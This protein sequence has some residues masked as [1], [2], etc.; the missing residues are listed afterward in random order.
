MPA[1]TA[2]D[3]AFFETNG[4]VVARAVISPEQAVSKPS[5]R[6]SPHLLSFRL[7]I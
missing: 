4:Y 5:P 2:A 3:L 7:G 6:P 1:L